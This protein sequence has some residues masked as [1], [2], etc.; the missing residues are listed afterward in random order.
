MKT[1]SN[2]TLEF[3][4]ILID[5][6][7]QAISQKAKDKL[8]SLQPFF[9]ESQC[10]S[11]MKE[12]SEARMILER[13]GTPPLSL[14]KE[15]DKIFDLTEIGSVLNTDQLTSIASFIS[16]CNRMKRYLK[17]AEETGTDLSFYGS[18]FYVIEHLYNEI[19]RS[20][21]NNAIDDRASPTLHDIRRKIENT[22][23][24]VREKLESMLRSKKEY[25]A[26]DY[27][28]TRKGRPV[29][30]VKKEYKNQV[31]G[32]VVDTSG[33][34]STYFIEPE[35]VRRLQDELSGLHIDEDNE[36]LK[37]LYTLTSL[38][39]DNISELKTNMDC[40][41]TLDFAF[42]K[43]KLSVKQKAIPVPVITERKIKII[44]GRHPLL[45]QDS[46]VPLDFEI[47]GDIRGV[48]I[49]GPNTGGKTV[50]LKTVGLLSLMAQSGLHI[51]AAEGSVLCMHNHILCDIGDG[52]SITENLS[53]F[54]SH[55]TNIIDI[56]K[57]VSGE[58]L[59]LLDELGS[60]TDPTEGKGLAIAILD[61]LK[62]KNCLF[63]ATTHYPEIKEFVKNT[64]SLINARMTFDRESLMPL[65]KLEIGEAG[66]SCALYIAQRLGFPGHLLSRAHKEAYGEK[67]RPESKSIPDIVF[68]TAN[69]SV[70]FPEGM[71][72]KE[73]PRKT[74]P[75]RS[76][77]FNIGDS[78]T[79]Y[80]QKEIG[81]VYKRTNEMGELG[82]QI[83]GRKQ[84]INHKRIKL[85]TPASELYP[86]DYDFAIVFDSVANRKAR[87]KMEKGHRPD[88]IIQYEEED[89]NT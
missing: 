66:E 54:S 9:S 62:Q 25:F 60:G 28:T 36:I 68:E 20:I 27:V 23:N 71:I 4:I 48:V 29:L 6:S 19:D 17:K 76:E 69:N 44:Q 67:N 8:L 79:V 34:G 80:P 5:L 49:T 24:A 53:T 39:D 12:T 45:K 37:I 87:H 40:M 52:Q 74:A 59:V 83:K 46:C 75:L 3:N 51:P 85:L 15:L 43:A 38:V 31:I 1:N 14:M 70:S 56:L 88:L 35:A 16:S 78:V 26:D 21:R 30:S 32:T 84:M 55:I 50:A 89:I 63:L 82:I 72:K 77:T 33:T 41:E 47:G 7:E 64:K 10:K 11:K 13:Y 86:E 65:Y 61:E 18:S 81:F 58:S 42:A 73:I 57:N 22:A 2:N